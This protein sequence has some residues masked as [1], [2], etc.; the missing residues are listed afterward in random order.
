M[1]PLEIESCAHNTT[2]SFAVEFG[3]GDANMIQ[4]SIIACAC[5]TMLMLR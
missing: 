3:H 4:S 1:Y 2:E 5:A